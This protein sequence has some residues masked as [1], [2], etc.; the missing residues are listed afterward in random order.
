M[1]TPKISEVL[2]EAGTFIQNAQA[3]A[4]ITAAFAG[5]GKDASFFE[6]GQARL[7]E[8]R[9]LHRKQEREYGDQYAA[10]DTLYEKQEALH[11]TYVRHL[12][13]ARIALEDDTD[14][15]TTLKL[16]G[17]RRRTILG[18]ID[19]VQAFYDNL[20]EN[21]DWQAAMATYNITPDDLQAGR[22]ELEE[23]V[24]ARRTQERETGEAQQATDARD[25]ALD[26]LD[27]WMSEARTLARLVMLDQPQKLEELGMLA[28]S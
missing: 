13:L 26:H 18:W 11:G 9:R 1:A 23:V 4:D 27:A 12:T 8:A 2:E 25:E 10:T 17:R 7:D 3:D 19:Q 24:Q 6:D 20:A 28:R 16:P 21:E 14:A 22:A 5:V 15:Q